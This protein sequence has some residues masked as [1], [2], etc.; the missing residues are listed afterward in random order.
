MLCLLATT[1][2]AYAQLKPRPD[3]FPPEECTFP[4]KAKIMARTIE[5]MA[6]WNLYPTYNVYLEMMERWT[7]QYPE[8]CRI[9]TIGT[10]VN[11]HLILSMEISAHLEDTTLPQFFYSSTIHGDEVTGYALMLHLID[12]LLSG[13]GSNAQYTDLINTT[14]ISINP[15]S[16]PDGTYRMGDSTVERS[17]RYNSN[18]VDLNRNYPDP[19]GPSSGTLAQENQ[20]MID[21]VSRR[22]FALSANLHGGSEV[23]NYPWDSFTSA[24]RPHPDADWWNDVCKRFVDTCHS[25]NNT[26]MRDVCDSGYLAG[27][28]WYIIPGGRQDYMNYYHNC[29]EM[30]LEISTIKTLPPDRLP[31]YWHCMQ[32][33]LVNYIGEVHNLPSDTVGIM[34]PESRKLSV[35]PNPTT[36]VVRVES[37]QWE[38]SIEVLD[39]HGKRVLT[40]KG[41]EVD[42]SPLPA[43]IYLLRSEGRVARVVK[44]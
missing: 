31:E 25:Y 9:D 42:L 41:N 18:Y 34:Q 16:N 26:H 10:S 13:Y 4:K 36:G 32:N 3:A 35:Y 6:E 29:L 38:K 15:L 2:P 14:F 1:L 30:T 23:L 33:A 17:I 24:E 11:G 8:L 44:Q 19:F 39:V 22:H 43:G 20:V 37:G 28:D 7:Q 27:G 40:A 12:T 5:Q 21:Y